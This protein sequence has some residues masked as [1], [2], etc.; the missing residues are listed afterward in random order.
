M[1][2]TELSGS[3]AGKIF[4]AGLARH[5]SIHEAP[6]RAAE[7]SDLKSLAAASDAVLVCDEASI[8]QI[9]ESM[10]ALWDE[11]PPHASV[12]VAL[13]PRKPAPRVDS[14][15]DPPIASF[16]C[17]ASVFRA[18]LA[19]EIDCY[20]ETL[21]FAVLRA[22]ATGAIDVD[23]L[24]VR[25]IP[26]VKTS[27]RASLSGGVALMMPHRGDPVYLNAS[28]KY[29][30][31]AAGTSLKVR[32]GLDE[33]NCDP[34]ASL[35]AFH[36]QVDFFSFGPAPVGPYVIRQELAERSPEP[37]LSLQDSDDLSTYDRFTTL[38][39][40]LTESASDIVG[41]HELCLD[42][43]RALVQPVRYPLDSNAA[44]DLCPNH[45][46]LHA[47]LLCRRDAFFQ[48]GGLATDLIIASDTQFLLRAYFHTRI[49]NVDEFLY[50]RR[51]HATSLTNAP[52]TIYDHPLRRSLSAAWTRDFNA[53]KRGELSL[54]ASTLWPKRRTEPVHIHRLHAQSTEAEIRTGT[55]TA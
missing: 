6:P 37:F 54:A 47:T 25:Q 28:L 41:S 5:Q 24:L 17:S 11:I 49:R 30:A 42:E 19:L 50:I 34:Y 35:P 27:S 12:F 38:A 40:A 2:L 44:L 45:A 32:V 9:A 46:L 1:H 16:L 23:R 14:Q 53:V 18:F 15:Y 8:S 39:A 3:A 31:R 26:F 52:E 55:A 33:T 48:A 22:I 36:P 7:K 10:P 43:M 51:R 29:L 13:V 20:P 21:C 4:A